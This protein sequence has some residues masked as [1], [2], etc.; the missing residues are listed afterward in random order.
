M[1]LETQSKR[2]LRYE[3]YAAIPDDGLRH[4]IVDGEHFVNAAPSP[5]HQLA[6]VHL[7]SELH[8]QI[9]IPRRGL[10]FVAPLDVELSP[11]VIV[12]PDI[13]IVLAQH[14]SIV[15]PTRIIGAPDVLIEII[16]TSTSKHDRVRKKDAYERSG[17]PE[18]WIVDPA[19]R[20]VEQYVL[21][22]GGYQL[23][24]PADVIR[25]AALPDVAVSLAEL[26]Q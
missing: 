18:Y 23:Q 17:V 9:A 19:A 7:V 12:Q 11:H 24:S 21:V 4:E 8:K 13:V 20:A 25:L 10:V 5:R 15:T 26:W 2:K 22:D 16:S 1:T 14:E 3:D 6:V